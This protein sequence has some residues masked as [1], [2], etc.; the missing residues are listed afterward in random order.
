[1]TTERYPDELIVG[2]DTEDESQSEV[3]S[4]A[5]SST[6]L[7]DSVLDYRLENGRTYHRYKDGK[8]TKPND[9]REMDR[10]EL[11][12]ELWLISLDFASGVAPPA[13]KDSK[14]VCSRALDVG[15]GT[16]SWAIDFADD[17]PESEQFIGSLIV[18][19]VPPN[20]KFEIDDLEED[21]T[22]SRPFSYIHSRVMT[23][24]V[25]DWDIYLRKI[26]KNLEPGGWVELQEL[27]V[28]V[29][30]DDGTLTEKH[31]LSQWS[32]LLHGASEKLGRPYIDPKSLNLKA[33]GF[34]DVSIT[35]FK[36]P[37]NEWPKDPKYKQLG[38]IQLENG[39]TGMEAF[40]MAA[41]T[42][43]YEW[44]PEEVNV[45]LV[46][47]RNDLRNKA[48]HAYMPAYVLIPP[49]YC[50]I[51]RKPEKGELEAKEESTA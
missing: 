27:D 33:A 41:F 30:S 22:W 19:S 23:G 35:T 48:I 8:Y 9:E 38:R 6:S 4:V 24:A 26:Y 29:T 21:W 18:L 13:Q 25:N 50:I 44:S 5:S 43:A 14:F 46:D 49:L 40:T 7:R 39:T 1:M 34:V 51:G 42:R 12:N 2:D 28:F 15:T 45:F 37:L 16:G 32:K 11:E 36:W 31:A 20:L 3:G 10:L 47:V 17:H